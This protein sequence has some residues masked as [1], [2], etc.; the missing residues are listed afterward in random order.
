MCECQLHWATKMVALIQRDNGTISS[1]FENVSAYDCEPE[2]TTVSLPTVS[3]DSADLQGVVVI[4][5]T[6][7]TAITTTGMRHEIR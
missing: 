3:S 1:E 2:S 5:E 4:F 7:T 6:G